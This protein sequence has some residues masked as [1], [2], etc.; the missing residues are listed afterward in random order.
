MEIMFHHSNLRLPLGV[1]RRLCRLVVTPRM[2]GIHHSIVKNETDSNWSTIFTWP[3]YLHGT[4]RLNV[5]QEKITI[6]VAAYQDP[7]E[8]TLGRVLALPFGPERH[9]NEPRREPLAIPLTTLA[10]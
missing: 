1:E 6:G 7:S 3:D 9:W 4:L 10:G 2:H 8:L 5:P